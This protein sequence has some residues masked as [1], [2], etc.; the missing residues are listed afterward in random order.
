MNNFQLYRSN[1][2]LGG[3]LKW[4]I[5]ID[6]SA[7]K[8]HVADFH[9]SPISDNIPFIYI[10]DDTLIYNTHQDNIK[11][12]Y[13][14]NKGNFY[15]EG[16]Y[17]DFTH[18]WPLINHDNSHPTIYSNIY[19]MGCRRSKR[20]S[21]YNKQFEFF[22]PVWL[23][24][25]DDDITFKINIH[26]SNSSTVLASNTLKLSPNGNKFHDRFVHYFKDY[27]NFINLKDGDDKLLYIN[28]K[29]KVANVHGLNVSTGLVQTKPVNSLI[30]NLSSRERPLM[31][32]D[33]ILIQSFPDNSFIC[34]QL[35][36][37]NLCFNIN[38][39]LSGG[40]INM[41][42]GENIIV[43]VDVFVGDK[44]IDKKDFYTNYDHINKKVWSDDNIDSSY[45]VLDYL[46]DNECVDLINKNKFG[47]SICH[48]AL[49]ENSE[50]IFNVYEGFSGLCIDKDD[51]NNIIIHENEHQ[52]ND[53]L[54][55][56]IKK[57]D[58]SQNTTGWSKILKIRT[59]NSFYKY[60]SNTAKNKTDG[61]YIY[62]NNFISNIKY[63]RLPNV[64]GLAFFDQKGMYLLK[65]LVPNKLLSTITNSI[66]CIDLYD[67]S[68][69]FMHKDD[70]LIFISNDEDCF[71]FGLFYDIL[72]NFISSGDIYNNNYD[73][74]TVTYLQQLYNM[75]SSKVDP[76]II[77][78]DSSIKYN[79][80][81]SPSINTT[82][83]EYFK[84]DDSFNYV[85][86][87]DGMIKPAFVD[88]N[89][90]L[91]YKDYV[92]TRLK[93]SPYALYG[94]DG[95]EPLFPSIDF[96]AIKKLDD[97]SYTKLPK[98]KVTE[99]DDLVDVYDHTHE[100]SWFNNSKC[101]ILNDI[102]KFTYINT[103]QEDGTYKMIDD[104]IYE[105]V[106]QYYNISDPKLIEYI[107]TQYEYDNNW[108]YYS[109]TNVDDYIYNITMKLK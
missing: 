44:Q 48:W 87:Y 58:N 83:V 35:F 45:N 100:Y 63:A 43:S 75:M 22:C 93:T 79:N 5:I 49:N 61:T 108:E 109:N 1:V 17:S 19:D 10:S 33:N 41:M 21:I 66:Q 68:L 34:K 47:Q 95:Q 84:D 16:L 90:I 37:F 57:A 52:Y 64:D 53:A 104:V 31:E 92:Y 29:D 73:N 77:V 24:H 26:T 60:I 54:N 70:L 12:Y 106:G 72:H 50:Y 88:K 97:W 74:I 42:L 85:I 101:I 99:Y 4:D 62:D 14:A 71:S 40:I 98:V 8:L 96:C 27:I 59:W 7:T 32:A 2:F 20:F 65:L 23:E 67:N 105:V 82:E 91:Y 89:D 38:D 36:N 28:F 81:P 94:K 69:Y 107:K 78:F 11:A 80:T 18:N 46:H 76:S 25:L 51:N 15:K 3:Q 9:L 30:D 55:T 102:I 103:P 56:F 86:R 13:A 39:I 6:S